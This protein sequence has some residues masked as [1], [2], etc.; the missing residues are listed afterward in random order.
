MPPGRRNRQAEP[1]QGNE[2]DFEESADD[3]TSEE[4]CSEEV[5]CGRRDGRRSDRQN[6]ES[7]D[8]DN[9][10]GLMKTV[11]SIQTYLLNYFDMLSSVFNLY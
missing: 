10:I 2:I 4:D 9:L 11:V 1:E 7:L 6:V 5:G 3:Y 8:D